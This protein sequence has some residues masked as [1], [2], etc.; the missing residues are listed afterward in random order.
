LANTNVRVNV[1]KAGCA[2]PLTGGF[3]LFAPPSWVNT[4]ADIKITDPQTGNSPL[5]WFHFTQ[6]DSRGRHS[7][8]TSNLR[9][10]FLR[11]WRRRTQKIFASTHTSIGFWY[12]SV[13]V[14]RLRF[15]CCDLLSSVLMHIFWDR[16]CQMTLSL[17]GSKWNCITGGALEIY[18]RRPSILEFKYHSSSNL[19]NLHEAVRLWY[20]HYIFERIF[21]KYI[22]LG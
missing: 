11:Q 6:S 2:F 18:N 8:T 20:N 10:H 19:L 14:S 22:V 16:P 5:S 12:Y 7:A 9:V 1:D 17:R 21:I 13:T 15:S 3:A 4:I